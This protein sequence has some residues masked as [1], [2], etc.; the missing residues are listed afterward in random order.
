MWN[1]II[2][3]VSK[4]EMGSKLKTYENHF[5]SI[6][7]RQI[8]LLIFDLNDF[9]FLS[10][11]EIK[12]FAH[13]WY[14]LNMTLMVQMVKNLPAIAGGLGL[15]P[16]LGR[17]LGEGNGN[18]L[19]YSCLENPMGRGYSSWGHRVGHNWATNTFTFIRKLHI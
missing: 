4:L 10:G 12:Y 19:Q 14:I 17:S 7:K 5:V 11:T 6:R 3:V 2:F 13:S 1:R 16:G 18:P 9:Y 15:I 8:G